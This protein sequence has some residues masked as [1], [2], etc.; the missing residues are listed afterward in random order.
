MKEENTQIKEEKFTSIECRE[1]DDRIQKFGPGYINISINSNKCC[2]AI[3]ASVLLN[4]L[5]LIETIIDM[6]LHKMGFFAFFRLG[7]NII[8]FFINII[9]EVKRDNDNKDVFDKIASVLT[10]SFLHFIGAIISII[11]IVNHNVEKR[12]IVGFC[13]NAIPSILLTVIYLCLFRS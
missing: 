4:C 3:L 9:I 2:A 1:G 8:I 10:N 12:L 7:I 5:S 13:V 6:P 11:Y